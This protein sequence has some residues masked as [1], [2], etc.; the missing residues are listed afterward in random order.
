MTTSLPQTAPGARDQNPEKIRAMFRA[1]TPSY[2]RLNRLFSGRLDQRWRRRAAH[3]A[4]AG[5]RPCAR[6]LDV[7]TGTGDLAQALRRAAPG[8]TVYGAD[9]THAMLAQATQKFAGPGFHWL[10][11]DGL[12]LPVGDGAFDAATIAFGLR[13]MTDRAAGLRE[14]ARAVRPGGRVAVLEFSQPRNRV[15]RAA[16]DFYSFRVMPRL[17]AWISGSDA[18]RYLAGSIREFWTPEELTRQM[19]EAGLGEV[20]AIE[21]MFGTVYLHVGTKLGKGEQA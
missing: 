20:R 6:L 15:Y 18:Y 10:E 3:E 7:A 2:D 16:Y 5:L 19:Q 14:M 11:A 8:A 4:T 13:N 21:L 12:R 1:I 9:F 17:G